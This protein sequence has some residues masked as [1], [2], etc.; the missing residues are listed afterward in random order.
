MS[1]RL[2]GR[3]G[4]QN[5]KVSQSKFRY[6]RLY[7]SNFLSFL[8]GFKGQFDIIYFDPCTSLAEKDALR[9]IGCLLLQRKDFRI[10]PYIHYA[11][12][13]LILFHTTSLKEKS[14]NMH[15]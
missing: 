1:K 8:E 3:K 7:E 14:P 11:R 6:V 9:L 12:N 10:T 4:F 2:G 5:F 15:A 13:S